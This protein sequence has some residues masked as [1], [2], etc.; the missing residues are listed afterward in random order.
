MS[1]T[2][3]GPRILLRRLR[4]LM[5]ENVGQQA[6]LDKIVQLIATS[7]E[8]A[9]CSVYLR[10]AKGVLELCATHGL[11]ADAV[12]KTILHIGEGLVGDIAQHKR[13]LNL[14]DAGA[15]P[16]FAH[17]PETGEGPYKSFVG[18][19]ILRGG[20]VTG[21]LVVQNTTARSFVDEEV[22]ALQTVAMVVAEM[23]AT[24]GDKGDKGKNMP[25]GY[26]PDVGGAYRG[27]GLTEGIV[28][29]HV[30]LH[31]PRIE[32]TKLIAE[33]S[34][35]EMRRLSDAVYQLRRNVDTM[36]ATE[37]VSHAGEHLAVL[38]AYRMFANDRGWLQRMQDSVRT[39]L[40]AEAAVQRVNNSMRARLGGQRDTYLRERMHDFED[41]SNRLLRILSG[42]AELASQDKLPRDAILVARTMGPAELLDYPRRKLRGLVLEEG[43][44]GA[45]VAI[46]ARALNIPLVGDVRGLVADAQDGAEIIV[47]ADKGEVHLNPASEVVASYSD[48]VR[49]L[50]RRQ[51][52]FARLRNLP[53]ITR[54]GRRIRLDM[55]AGL[56]VDVENMD[57]IGADNI[58]LFRTELQ[59]MVS[60]RMPRQAEQEK[61]YR[62]IIAAAGHR[63]IIFRT[64]DIGGDKV[65]P[66]LRTRPED[67]PSMGWRAMRM[68]LD[69]PG[70]VRHQIR[71]LLRATGG[72]ELNVMFPLITTINEFRASRDLLYHERDRLASFGHK[73]PDRLTIGTM[74][75]VPALVWQLDE[76]LPEIDF[77]SVGTND[78]MQFFFAADRGNPMIGS[79]Y[80][81][82]SLPALRMLIWVREKAHQYDVPVSI[83]GELG[84]HPLEAMALL[85]L[86]YERFSLPATAIGAVKRMIRSTH[87]QRLQ[88]DM[89]ALMNAPPDDIRSALAMMADRHNI[90][91]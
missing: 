78:L 22:E 82:L 4:Q 6:R 59:F 77:L 67:N 5:A 26:L 86:G 72:G 12:H 32:I 23:L 71:A 46:V 1:L 30:V 79:R 83:C 36:L 61:F 63:D 51:K 50:A 52:N 58:G 88:A 33:D 25:D 80:D 75:E 29:G 3:E 54:D 56:M 69:R 39:G 48:R 62:A 17:R 43:A 90:R 40:T 11:N 85:G 27:I 35:A 47:D 70:L 31:E 9:V 38:E 37:D 53:A 87:T 7:M 64:V 42:R 13:A 21:V 8:A 49:L 73:M 16:R 10:R 60:A 14:A 44:L 89:G 28:T 45:H 41:L 68:A 66:Y 76:L 24:K 65:L 18:V 20:D 55:N 34:D 57:N 15:H 2:V 84:P 74:L 81:F 19:P 91:L